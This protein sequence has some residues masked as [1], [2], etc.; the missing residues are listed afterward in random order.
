MTTDLADVSNF[1]SKHGLRVSVRSVRDKSFNLA[2]N[3]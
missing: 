3:S 1:D 2:A